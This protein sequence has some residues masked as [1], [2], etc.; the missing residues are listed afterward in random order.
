MSSNASVTIVFVFRERLSPT[1][2]CLQNLL[3]NTTGPYELI[4]V[5][6]GSPAAISASLRELAATHGFT[7]LR[8]E[9][10]LS[11]N[12]SRNLALQHVQTPYVA[13]VDN[14][15]TV[16]PGWLDPLLRC[17]EETG[18]WLVAPLY[19]Q[20]VRG[21][22]SVHMFGGTVGIRDEHGRPAYFEQHQLAHQA[23]DD[24][25]Q[26]M[27]QETDLI[28]FHALLMNMEAY[29]TLGPLDE[30]FF[31][32]S[33]HA[34]LSLTVKNA[35]KPIYLEP[36]SVITYQIPDH[37]EPMDREYFALRWSEA[38]TQASL[39]RLAEKYAIPRKDHG[40]RT[41]GRWVTRHRQGAMTPYPRLRRL[42]GRKWHQQFR[43]FVGQPLDKWRSARQY[44][45]SQYVSNRK[46]QA[47]II[48]PQ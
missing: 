29:R 45:S 6:G 24:K 42:L 11:P 30:K 7:V 47:R 44:P 32:C 13:F 46:V 28:E 9:E 27:R 2:P 1:L 40:I 39:Q 4:C 8:S 48:S 36:A 35:G 41:A 10:Y 23:L 43:R 25:R 18:A 5:D 3:S 14:D 20:S 34:D 16:S 15:V 33:E 12:E 19:M 17:A 31:S 38:W 21:Q 37:L 22:L 26:L